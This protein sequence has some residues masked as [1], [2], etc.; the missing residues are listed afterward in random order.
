MVVGAIPHRFHKLKGALWAGGYT[1]ERDKVAPWVLLSSLA[2]YFF[3]LDVTCLIC[4][5]RTQ[6]LRALRGFS[7]IQVWGSRCCQLKQR[8]ARADFYSPVPREYACFREIVSPCPHILQETGDQHQLTGSAFPEPWPQKACRRRTVPPCFSVASLDFEG[9]EKEYPIHF[10][11]CPPA[12]DRNVTNTH[13][14]E[15]QWVQNQGPEYPWG[16]CLW[17]VCLVLN[18]EEKDRQSRTCSDSAGH[19]TDGF[20][21]QDL[22]NLTLTSASERGSSLF[23]EGW[24][25]MPQDKL[26]FEETDTTKL[27]IPT[28]RV[29]SQQGEG[30]SIR[31]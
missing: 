13:T 30:L 26:V 28:V 22:G 25:I 14:T 8:R 12:A 27:L 17:I 3:F 15:D 31:V 1:S 5:R 21:Y 6:V 19:W 20:L 11:K 4:E 16:R 9:K 23:A 24:S 29:G 2:H 18:S 10:G 7:G